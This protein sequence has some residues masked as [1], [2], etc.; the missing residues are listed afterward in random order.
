MVGKMRGEEG[1]LALFMALIMPLVIFA[2]GLA[3]DF[4]RAHFVKA[5]LQTAA[6]AA[7]L[8]GA[9]TAT[10]VPV[11]REYQPVMDSSGN[12]TGFKEVITRW[13]AVIQDDA[14]AD[15]EA[16]LAFL[17]NSGRLGPQAGVEFA[18]D[19]GNYQGAKVS[20]DSYRV[21]AAARVKAP[22]AGAAAALMTGDRSFYLL[23]VRAEGT[24]QAIVQ[25][26][27]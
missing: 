9:M 4:G 27:D 1:F 3:V 11:E 26:K 21:Q 12:I 25:E 8:A 7:A 22:W 10:P 6:D 15:S 17:A 16:R 24:G 18:M 2:W 23:P 20:E 5:E 14:R 19:E 13:K